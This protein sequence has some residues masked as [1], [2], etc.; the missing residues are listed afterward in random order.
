[1]TISRFPI[2]ISFN[3]HR[4]SLSCRRES[5]QDED[6]SI[7]DSPSN[8][9]ESLL[10][11]ISSGRN[12]QVMDTKTDTLFTAFPVELRVEV[13]LQFCGM[14]CPIGKDTEGPVLLLQVCR[15]WK[16]LALQTPQLWTS[17]ALD[18]RPFPGPK[19]SEFLISALKGWI[20]RSRN[21]PLSFKLRYPGPVSDA[22]CTNLIQCI[23]P[24]SARWRDV[25]LTVPSTSLL[26]LWEV[27]PNS[28]PSLRTLSMETAG[29]CPFV[30]KNLGI[31]WAQI[32]ELNLALITFPTLDECLY[33]LQEGP[34]LKRCSMDAICVF[35]SN[36]TKR[37]PLPKL[38]HLQ[39]TAYGGDNGGFLPGRP[40]TQFIAFLAALSLPGLESLKIGWGVTRGP[41]QS[42]YWSDSHTTGFVDFLQGLG[43][44]LKTL[45]LE[46]LPF[47]AQQVLR[48]LEVVPCLRHL[49]FSMSQADWAHDFIND[50][51]LGALTQQPGRPE[52]SS[53]A[54]LH[55]VALEVSSIYFRP[56]RRGR[57]L[58]TQ[59]TCRVSPT[60]FQR[61]EGREIGC[62]GSVEI[63]IQDGGSAFVV[64]EQ[65]L[66][67][68]DDL[69]FERRLS[70]GHSPVA[71][72][73]LL[74]IGRCRSRC[75]FRYVVCK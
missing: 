30:L 23:L 42:Y 64:S 4:Q 24:S 49:D 73:W 55:C 34:N 14:Y 62:G 35:T 16:E 70:I 2:D 66:L 10:S 28:F 44:H 31:N 69:F 71:H 72:M 45:R 38:E 75:R 29:R 7:N 46:C 40:E 37:F 8:V 27:K 19:K 39:L 68:K 48:C 61:F 32:T 57:P 67:R 15:A 20:D 33:I 12:R 47:N 36:D 26:P 18:F 13:F 59:T 41:D 1:M 21:L 54:P 74:V 50:E 52:Q 63:R 22:T 51:L 58:F 9:K 5:L 11:R 3:C 6:G 65:R 56:S 17:F 25:S 53:V 43:G 60:A